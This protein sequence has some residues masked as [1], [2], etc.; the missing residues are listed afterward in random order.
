MWNRAEV[1]AKGK[2]AFKRNYWTC[3]IVA[4]IITLLFAGGSSNS[5]RINLNINDQQLTPSIEDVKE[6]FSPTLVAAGIFL[7]V[8]SIFIFNVLEVG[9]RR[10]FLMNLFKPAKFSELKFGFT[11][12]YVRNVA[13]MLVKDILIA[14][15]LILFIIPGIV[16]YYQYRMVPYILSEKP[17]LTVGEVLSYSKEMMKGNKMAT[18]IYDMSFIGW[19]ILATCTFGILGLFYVDPYKSS[20][21]AELYVSIR[22]QAIRAENLAASYAPSYEPETESKSN[23]ENGSSRLDDPFSK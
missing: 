21:D 16:M 2:A 18:F 5:V 11:N 15:G 22:S 7:I 19:W 12:D 13:T 4:L 14:I 17:E 20:S 1:K 6:A 9:C 10:F 8:L 3:V 23:A